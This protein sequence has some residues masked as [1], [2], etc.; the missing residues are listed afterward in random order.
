MNKYEAKLLS[1]WPQHHSGGMAKF[2][3]RYGFTWAT[4]P[5]V[6]TAFLYRL[7]ISHRFTDRGDVAYI[8]GSGLLLGLLAGVSMWRRME[9]H[10]ANL[11]R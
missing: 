10:Y 5:W 9:R 4:L 1:R 7:F 11:P 8:V 3:L 6:A 2:V